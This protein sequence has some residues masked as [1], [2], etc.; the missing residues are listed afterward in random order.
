MLFALDDTNCSRFYQKSNS[1]HTGSQKPLLLIAFFAS[2]TPGPK[3]PVS[4]LTKNCLQSLFWGLSWW[5]HS[6]GISWNICLDVHILNAVPGWCLQTVNVPSVF[7]FASSLTAV[8]HSCIR[9]QIWI[10]KMCLVSS[11]RRM[12]TRHHWKKNHDDEMNLDSDAE[13]YD[14]PLF[15]FIE[16]MSIA[17]VFASAFC[18]LCIRC[19]EEA[20]IGQISTLSVPSFV[21]QLC[22]HQQLSGRLDFK[23]SCTERFRKNYRRCV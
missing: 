3:I 14:V 6:P 15:V 20:S 5:H 8:K 18:F 12:R 4:N 17:F 13:G 10:P 16:F 7:L 11:A 23:H 2:D 9:L 19:L 21:F 1:I 22:V